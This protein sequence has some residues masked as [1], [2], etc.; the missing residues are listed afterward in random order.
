MFIFLWCTLIMFQEL[1][2]WRLY[3]SKHVATFMIDNKLVV[4]WL[5]QL[6]EYLV[7]VGWQCNGEAHKCN[8]TNLS[9]YTYLPTYLQ[10]SVR[11]IMSLNSAAL[12]HIASS[13]SSAQ[14]V[15]DVLQGH[16]KTDTVEHSLSLKT[17]SLL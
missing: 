9:T 8:S 2:V 14:P 5:N 15:T 17:L 12:S 10:R 7:A 16:D 4:Y 11:F 6:L 3:E 1:A 13:N